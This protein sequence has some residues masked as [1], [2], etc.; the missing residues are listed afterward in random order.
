MRELAESG[1]LENCCA[2]NRTVGSNPTLSAKCKFTFLG[3]RMAR[4]TRHS[5]AVRRKPKN[6]KPFIPSCGGQ[7]KFKK[8]V[9][10]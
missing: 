9:D 10:L 3:L 6:F 5:P 2:G 7:K 1:S 4:Q 8:P